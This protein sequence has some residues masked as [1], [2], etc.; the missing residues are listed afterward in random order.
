MPT[1]PI[2]SV[3]YLDSENVLQFITAGGN[4]AEYQ[5]MFFIL[6]RELDAVEWAAVQEAIKNPY[7]G[8]MVK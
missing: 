5:V 4:V 6:A 7:T 2:V 8:I 1:S 3:R